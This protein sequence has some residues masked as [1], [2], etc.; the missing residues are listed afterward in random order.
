M[1]N[2]ISI[3]KRES[4]NINY[5]LVDIIDEALSLVVIK[6]HKDIKGIDSNIFF[7]LGLVPSIIMDLY[8]ASA[9]SAL[10]LFSLY[11]TLFFFLIGCLIELINFTE[12]WINFNEFKNHYPNFHKIV[13]RILFV[14]IFMI[15]ISIVLLGK[16][17]WVF[18]KETIIHKLKD[19]K[20]NLD[21]FSLKNKNNNPKGPNDSGKFFS[22]N[23]KKKKEKKEILQNLQHEKIRAQELKEKLLKTQKNGSLLNKK[24]HG[25]NVSS[26][27]SKNRNWTNTIEIPKESDFTIENQIKNLD[28]EFKQYDD[29]DKKF[30]TI[31]VNIQK[32]KENFY[33]NESKDMFKE[34]VELVNIL[35]KN[36]KS[37]KKEL[38][39]FINKK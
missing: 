24:S 32:K 11:L 35:K 28:K 13:K 10:N 17:L 1:D 20:L 2:I 14:F 30:K 8:V 22:L 33:P 38:T 37:T 3:Y 26:S 23:S 12:K 39:K 31:V 15:I 16:I 21:Y 19:L 34:Y 27:L 25:Y 9:S 6:I 18:L 4:L 36:L 29:Q 5:S 7:F